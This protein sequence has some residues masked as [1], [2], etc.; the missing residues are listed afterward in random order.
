M[1]GTRTTRRMP[2]I[3]RLAIIALAGTMALLVPP[4]AP[5]D[6]APRVTAEQR[7]SAT[8]SLISVYSP[9]MHRT[10]RAHVLHPAGRP[11]GLPTFYM[12]P[13]AGGAED[14]I[15][16]YNNTPVRRFFAD[17]RT[18]VVLP[19]G[20][21][22]SMMTD[23]I[24]DDPILGRNK[25]QTFVNRELPAAVNRAFRT[26]GVSALSGV[27]MSAGP[28]LDLATQ[29]PGKYRA[30]AAYSGCPGAADPLG[31]IAA[32]AIVARGGGNVLN[33]W[34]PPGGPAWRAHDPVLNA[35]KLRGTA[36]Y[37]SAGSGLPGPVDGDPLRTGGGLVGG[38]IM[39][40][41]ALRCTTNMA[42]RLS[43]LGIPHTFVHRPD[44]VHTWGL[45]Y[46]DLRDSWPMI[47]RAIG[48]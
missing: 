8:V 48:A 31:T 40:A 11:S 14:G 34:G 23:W 5:A 9:S 7:I 10:I 38:N 32:T 2:W 39:E 15:S 26:N 37:L 24:S 20:G 13:G 36:V 35:A 25:W 30:V 12:L 19:I 3:A 27:S 46:A 18:N 29:A 33:M 1:A 45:F 6:A 22:F 47:A 28:A 44:G 16:W 41:I 43:A 42:D 21:R 4:A 17:K